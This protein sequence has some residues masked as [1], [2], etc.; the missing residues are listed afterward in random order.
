MS[1]RGYASQDAARWGERSGDKQSGICGRRKFS[2]KNH[3]RESQARFS[4]RE[5][6][7]GKTCVILNPA[8]AAGTTGRRQPSI[9]ARIEA[10]LGPVELRVTDGLGDARGLARAATENG[11]RRILVAGGDGTLSEIANGILTATKGA[12]GG[13]AIGLLPLGSG[14]D[15]ARTLGLPRDFEEALA[16]IADGRTRAVDVLRVDHRDMTGAPRS[17]FVV[18]EASAGLSGATVRFVGRFAKRLGA[19]L[20]FAA[21]ALAAIATHR[22]E[23]MCVRIDDKE[24]YM[25]P[26]SLIVAANGRYFGAGMRV[27]PGAIADDGRIEVV[28]IR[29]L[30]IPRLLKNFPSIFAG[31]HGNHP[32]VSF[33]SA[34][35]VQVSSTDSSPVDLDGEPLGVIPMNVAILP[36]VLEVITGGAKSHDEV[37]GSR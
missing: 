10:V 24:V 3:R 35:K 31:T 11:C 18:N 20:G 33:Y 22:A 1:Y 7:L 25:G 4:Y 28:L 23:K 36:R 37:E 27:A 32:S 26:V 5:A 13:P 12:A 19:R 14:W 17:G 6:V 29:G 2:K 15:F 16:C 21:G 8:S 34:K 30:S 9:V